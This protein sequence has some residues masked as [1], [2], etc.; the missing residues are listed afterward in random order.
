MAAVVADPTPADPDFDLL[1]SKLFLAIGFM[2]IIQFRAANPVHETFGL[3]EKQQKLIVSEKE[4][5]PYVRMSTSK[6]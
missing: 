6:I 1:E 4:P 3:T 5:F 2:W